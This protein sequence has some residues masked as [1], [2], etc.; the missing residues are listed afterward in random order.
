MQYTDR[1]G[2]RKPQRGA[3][4]DPAN[5]EDLNY[6]FDKLDEYTEKLIN[7]TYAE[8]KELRDN[9]QLV[10]G[11]QYRITDYE[12]IINGNVTYNGETKTIYRSAGHQFDIIVVA[13]DVN[14][15]N[16]NARAAVHAGDT[17][18]ANCDL[19]AW[20]IKYCIDNDTSRFNLAISSGKGVI[21]ELEDEYHNYCGYDF[22]NLQIKIFKVSA[23]TTNSNYVN[24]YVGR[25]TLFSG[26]YAITPKNSTFNESDFKWVYTFTVVDNTNWTTITDASTIQISG[27]Y[28]YSYNYCDGIDKN[29]LAVSPNVFI[30]YQNV[31]KGNTLKGNSV[32]NLFVGLY[33]SSLTADYFYRNTFGYE[34]TTA[35]GYFSNNTFGEFC[36]NNMIGHNCTLNSFGNN[37]SGITLG[38]SCSANSIGNGCGTTGNTKPFTLGDSCYNN[39]FGNA[40]INN[41]LGNNS[42]N[43]SFGNSCSN[44]HLGASCT[45]NSFSNACFSNTLGDSCGTNMFGDQCYSNT[46]GNNCSRNVLENGCN[47]NGIGASVLDLYMTNNCNA[48][49][50][51]ASVVS[52]KIVKQKSNTT[53][54][55]SQ[56][57]SVITS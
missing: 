7:I 35:N 4:A 38:N 37:C 50:V 8:L 32:G 56:N 57:Y 29:T 18:F 42:S 17:Y 54:T 13:D 48:N 10:P 26:S 27:G 23:H 51:N 24:K 21:W 12:T 55:T 33:C 14:I 52:L 34:V 9:S 19:N 15:L 5:I 39:S 11:Q 31:S 30:N 41:Q 22:K 16:E 53:F 47:N 40:C 20:K 3:N 44:I 43:N 46:L 1:L 36:N 6:N 49:T 45:N 2:L 25:Y 28:T